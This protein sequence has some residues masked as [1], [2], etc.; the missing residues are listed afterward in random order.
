MELKG[1]TPVIA[2]VMLMLVTVGIAGAAYAWFGGIYDSSTKNFISIPPGG[3][4]CINNKIKVY[5]L[6]NGNAQIGANDIV[7]ADVDG[8]NVIN[9]GLAGYWKFDDGSGTVAKDSSGNGNDGTL[10][11]MEQTD[12]VNGKI[13]SALSFDSVNEKVSIAPAASLNTPAAF[14]WAAW[15][16]RAGVSADGYGGLWYDGSNSETGRNRIL[17]SNDGGMRAQYTGFSAILAPSGSVPLNSW[18]HVALAFTGTQW[19]YYV[20]AINVGSLTESGTITTSTSARLIGDGNGYLFN[21]MADEVRIYSRA[22]TPTEIK[23]L[24]GIQP[25]DAAL[26]VDYTAGPGKHSVRIGTSSGIAETTVNCG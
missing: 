15:I 21:G 19:I 7:V 24:H 11:N 25:G 6:N 17:L 18:N 5:V 22:L 26:A 20:N 2:L 10:T 12:W 3:A 23:F 13:G 8:N 9:N 14:T 4:Y 1:I 16:Y